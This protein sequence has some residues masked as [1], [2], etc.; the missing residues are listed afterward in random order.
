[1][2]ADFTGKD[3]A[4]TTALA[5]T[6]TG[7]AKSLPS[8]AATLARQGDLIEL[9]SCDPGASAAKSAT[10]DLSTAVGVAVTRTQLAQTFMT[11]RMTAAEAQCTARHFLAAFSPADLTAFV[12]AQSEADLP[13]SIET[14]ARS[15]A[16]ACI[17]T[18]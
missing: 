7:W 14:K 8:G 3:A 2:R 12:N 16:Q 18:K 11:Q 6:L 9:N 4:A 15:A 1:M 10:G 17:A 5:G 13:P